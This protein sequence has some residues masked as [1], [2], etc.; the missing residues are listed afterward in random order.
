MRPLEIVILAAGK[1]TRM[2]SQLPK[3][4]HPIAGQSM[5]GHV[6]ATARA[7]SPR[8]IHVVV[9]DDGQ[10]LQG[11]FQQPVNWVTQTEQL[12]TGHAVLQALP[13]ISNDAT[14]LVLFG[15]VPLIQQEDLSRCVHAAEEG[16]AI[17]SAHFNDP[18]QLG[19]I[20][21]G[22]DNQVV[23]IVEFADASA[24]QR[25]IKEINS[26]IM[27][28]SQKQ[29]K[30]LLDAVEP[31]NAQGE[32]YLTD[33]IALA[34]A[35]SIPVSGVAVQ[36]AE[37]VHGVNDRHQLAA[38]ERVMQ[39]R[40][41]EQL[42]KEGVS[43]ADPARL[44]IRGQLSTGTD[45]FI[46][47][48]VVFKGEVTLGNNVT[49]GPGC[50]IEDSHL[51]NDV[52]VKPNTVIEGAQI[53]AKC[54]LGPFARIR[55]GTVLDEDVRIGNFVE[56]KKARLGKGTKAGHL[57][58]LG[59]ATIGADCN[60]GAGTVTCNYDGMNKH[61][62]NIGDDVFVGTNSTL[63]APVTIESGAFVAAGSTITTKVSTGDLAVGRG[64]QRNITGWTR[65]DK[66]AKK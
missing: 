63:V 41:A 65:P 34:V 51:G 19:R 61:H 27:A 54:Q 24:E 31:A 36:Q 11:A 3:V 7:L 17:V 50:V 25:D 55:P 39:R 47:V 21:R 62:T 37:S 42:M 48:N 14:V 2:R 22:S 33:V 56:T 46:D 52:L 29:L 5:L 8:A 59:D 64:K 35:Q 12:G 30:Q 45:C 16:V 15:D 26:G 49:I 43:L 18:A 10:K 60:I 40:L 44:D 53:D 1:G 4:L 28:A 58:Y 66:R 23:E 57:A 6:V 38:A 9:G 20:I 32:Y 13:E